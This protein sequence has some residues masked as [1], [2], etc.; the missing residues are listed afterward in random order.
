M[1]EL[2]HLDD[3]LE[4][5]SI[6]SES[7]LYKAIGFIEAKYVPSA[8]KFY[9]GSFQSFNIN[10]PGGLNHALAKWLA[11]NPQLL[12]QPQL[13]RVYPRSP[14]SDS[15]K[16]NFEAIAAITCIDCEPGK[17]IIRGELYKWNENRRTFVIKVKRNISI[18][19][20]LKNSQLFQ[21]SF[22]EIKGELP[23][24]P[25]REQFWQTLCFLDGQTFVLIKAA[26]LADKCRKT[27]SV[28][29]ALPTGNEIDNIASITQAKAEIILKF[30]TIPKIRDLPNKR[31]EFDLATDEGTIFTVNIKAKTWRSAYKKIEQ[32]DAWKATV[33][34]KLGKPSTR[35]F[36]LIE[37]GFQVF[38]ILPKN[39]NTYNSN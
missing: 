9:K 33:K 26:L 6:I 32:M 35:G 2:S 19:D 8:D 27:S 28:V 25:K 1:I 5:N 34:G 23:T 12:Q 4:N 38:E 15:T 29:D 24:S 31:I 37:A 13:W 21:P 18:P 10:Y 39:N 7:N 17:F 22:L 20:R 14:K 36:E 30:N 3:N 11:K 16:L